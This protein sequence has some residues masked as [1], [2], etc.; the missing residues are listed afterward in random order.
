MW[1]QNVWR[2]TLVSSVPTTAANIFGWSQYYLGQTV[3]DALSGAQYYAYGVMSGDKEAM[4][5]GKVYFQVQGAKFR[6]F[7]DPFTTHDAYWC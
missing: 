3:A 1:F 6:N 2:R 5:V 4:R 7:L